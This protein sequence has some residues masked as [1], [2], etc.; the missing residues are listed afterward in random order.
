[1]KKLICFLAL[2]A[3]LVLPAKAAA[4]ENSFIL[5]AEADGKV[6]IAPEYVS[7]SEGQ[8]V[9][10]ALA[11]S[12]H[13]FYG[14]KEGWIYEIDGIAGEFTRSDETGNYSLDN[15]ASNVK[16]FRFSEE[17]E[18][19]AEAWLQPLMTAMADYLTEEADIRKAAEA[20]QHT[21]SNGLHIRALLR[22]AFVQVKF[23]LFGLRQA[24]KA[25]E[26]HPAQ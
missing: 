12:G 13:D 11:N 6:I 26:Q 22:A 21:F 15:Q 7:Y 19:A 3:A 16:Y 4:P 17:T 18:S 14:L 1:M 8:T 5:S 25:A 9:G 23:D 20:F 24:F 2:C 10:E